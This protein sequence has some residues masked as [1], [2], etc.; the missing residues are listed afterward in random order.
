[1]SKQIRASICYGVRLEDKC[2]LTFSNLYGDCLTVRRVTNALPFVRDVHWGVPQGVS[3][4]HFYSWT[5]LWWRTSLRWG[6]QDHLDSLRQWKLEKRLHVSWRRSDQMRLPICS[7][8]E[9]HITD[10][11]V[12]Q[13]SVTV[14][15]FLLMYANDTFDLLFNIIGLFTEDFKIISARPRIS[16]TL[17]NQH[18]CLALGYRLDWLQVDSDSNW[19]VLI[20]ISWN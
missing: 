16:R 18:P 5:T 15:L 6:C 4:D 19:A 1:M 13:V 7:W 17:G 8:D 14:L 20:L 12:P 11:F 2:R 10:S 3:S 9:S